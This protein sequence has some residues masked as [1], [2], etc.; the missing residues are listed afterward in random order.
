MN[1][2]L[3]LTVVVCCISSSL[4]SQC[5]V[6]EAEY[7]DIINGL[8]IID[9]IVGL[10]HLSG[11]TKLIENDSVIFHKDD[12]YLDYWFIVPDGENFKVCHTD[13]T[14]LQEFN[15]NFYYQDTSLY[16]YEVDYGTHGSAIAKAAL[17][18]S[19]YLNKGTAKMIVYK[20][21]S[22]ESK[23]MSMGAK[24]GQSIESIFYWQSADVNNFFKTDIEGQEIIYEEMDSLY[25]SKSW[26]TEKLDQVL[27]TSQNEFVQLIR[28]R[29]NSMMIF[30]TIGCKEFPENIADEKFIV[31]SVNELFPN[32]I[33]YF[34][35]F[36]SFDQYVWRVDF[37]INEAG[38][39]LNILSFNK[40]ALH[41]S[42]SIELFKRLF[43]IDGYDFWR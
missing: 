3:S 37:E 14:S 26:S 23:A 35:L 24:S 28:E 9:P 31:V 2:Y 12:P 43:Q 21:V 32:R 20:L 27:E 16:E 29:L 6:T 22:P 40:S 8:E 38:E 41:N 17:L 39:P 11:E 1:K 30:S 42:K 4:L 5:L 25:S 36:E 19:S 18:D 33:S 10:W 7:N 13:Y 15:A 34:I